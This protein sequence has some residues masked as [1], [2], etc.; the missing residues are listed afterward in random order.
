MKNLNVNKYWKE[1]KIQFVMNRGWF[2]Q[3]FFF[4]VVAK[5]CVH[6]N[7]E[8]AVIIHYALKLTNS[9]TVEGLSIQDTLF[10]RV[11]FGRL[12]LGV[13]ELLHSDRK[14]DSL[15]GFILPLK[16]SHV[17]YAKWN[18]MQLHENVLVC[19]LYLYS[20]FDAVTVVFM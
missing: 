19:A 7:A 16:F 5:M 20:F 3:W 8:T 18:D 14:S 1:E 2:V 10:I 15:V 11:L 17:I 13:F 4:L 12:I 6:R 9:I